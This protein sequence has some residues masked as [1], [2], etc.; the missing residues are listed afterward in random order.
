TS[1]ISAPISGVVLARRRQRQRHAHAARVLHVDQA[2]H[3]RLPGEAE[4]RGVEVIVVFF[5]L[6]VARD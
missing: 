2:L 4:V 6:F 5:F 3:V 1:L